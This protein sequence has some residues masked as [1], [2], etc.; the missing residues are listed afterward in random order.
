MEGIFSG[1]DTWSV[2]ERRTVLISK[3]TV[4]IVVCV[5]SSPPF[6]NDVSTSS[7]RFYIC[8]LVLLYNKNKLLLYLILQNYY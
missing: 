4:S 1:R 8:R 3:R 6:S 5:T 2:E 7:S